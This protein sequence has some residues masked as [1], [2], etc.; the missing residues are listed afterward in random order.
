MTQGPMAGYQDSSRYATSRPKV[1]MSCVL[2]RRSLGEWLTGHPSEGHTVFLAACRIRPGSVHPVRDLR[3]CHLLLA[4]ITLSSRQ[5]AHT[6]RLHRFCQTASTKVPYPPNTSSSVERIIG[7]YHACATRSR[8]NGSLWTALAVTHLRSRSR[9]LIPS[10]SLAEMSAPLPTSR[11]IEDGQISGVFR[12][13]W[14]D[15]DSAS[16]YICAIF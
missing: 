4:A 3:S 15:I 11:K 6:K 1:S 8:S 9:S 13:G 10:L 16:S 14:G 5:G 7:S 2:G 12:R